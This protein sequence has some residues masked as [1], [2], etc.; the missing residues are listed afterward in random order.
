MEV[1]CFIVVIIC[2]VIVNRLYHKIFDVT[3]FGCRAVITEWF[4][5]L[6]IGSLFAAIPFRLLGLL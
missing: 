6:I 4:F 5:C 1:V 3:Y 2:A